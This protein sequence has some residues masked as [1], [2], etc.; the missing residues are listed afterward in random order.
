MTLHVLLVFV[1]QFWAAFSLFYHL[2]LRAVRLFPS[3]YTGRVHTFP[4][5]RENLSGIRGNSD[6]KSLLMN[7]FRKG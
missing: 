1:G 2:S 6:Y 7:L 4:K 5:E 3:R